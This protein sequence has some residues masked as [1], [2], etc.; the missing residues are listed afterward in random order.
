MKIKYEYSETHQLLIWQNNSFS[1]RA[2]YCKEYVKTT[3]MM[4]SK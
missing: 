4:V 1:A 2:E 3:I